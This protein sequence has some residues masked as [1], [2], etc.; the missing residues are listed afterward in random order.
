MSRS[1]ERGYCDRE[2]ASGGRGSQS[3]TMIRLGGWGAQPGFQLLDRSAFLTGPSLRKRNLHDLIP[4]HKSSKKQQ[5]FDHLYLQ[6][7]IPSENQN[8]E[9]RAR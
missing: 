5:P 8:F 6:S 3:T 2:L 7:R 9:E 4:F 1:G